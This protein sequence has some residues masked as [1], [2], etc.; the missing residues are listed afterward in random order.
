MRFPK[1]LQY[2]VLVLLLCMMYLYIRTFSIY[3]LCT[4]YTCLQEPI[5][6]AWRVS[7]VTSTTSGQLPS[8][9]RC[10]FGKSPLAGK[11]LLTSKLMR[12]QLPVGGSASFVIQFSTR[13]KLSELEFMTIV[14]LIYRTQNRA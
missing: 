10:Q 3:V 6:E 9:I 14:L 5:R 7:T 8:N 12:F 11:C 4:N 1:F 2:G 13:N